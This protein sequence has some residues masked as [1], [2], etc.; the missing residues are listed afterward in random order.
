MAEAAAIVEFAVAE[1]PR[2]R[3]L[4]AGPNCLTDAELLALVLRTGNGKADAVYLARMLLDRFGGVLGVLSSSA[5]SLL[6]VPGLGDAK[7]AA[8]L[9]IREL[10][11]RAEM[12]KMKNAPVVSSSD[13]VRRY[14]GMHLAGEEREVF[15]A[16]LLDTRHRLLGVEDI[17]LG[18]IDRTMVYPREVAKCCLRHNAAAVVLFHNHPSGSA[19]P[20]PSD[21]ELTERLNSVLNEIDVRLLDHVVVA[22][23]RK[24][25]MAERGM[26]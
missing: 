15:G 5:E 3:L 23:L 10:L 18:S 13:E 6:A 24:V 1:R 11:E 25:S 22:G 12:A 26:L 9:A 21:R 4:L 7:V 19:E 17:F 2:E 14:L 8:L 16:L 20:S